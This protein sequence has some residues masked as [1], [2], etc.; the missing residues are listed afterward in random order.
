MNTTKRIPLKEFLTQPDNLAWV[1]QSMV[2]NAGLPIG[3]FCD[4]VCGHFDIRDTLGNLQSK[5]CYMALKAMDR[6]GKLSL[7][8]MLGYEPVRAGLPHRPRCLDVPPPQPVGLPEDAGQLMELKIVMARTLPQ[9]KTWNTILEEEHYIGASTPPGRLIKYM[10]YADGQLAAAGCFCA[11]KLSVWEREEWIG[12]PAELMKLRRDEV[13]IGMGRYVVREGAHACRNLASKVLGAMVGAVRIDW[14]EKYRVEP[15]LI[16]TYVDPSRFDGTCYKAANWIYV[17][18]TSGRGRDD[19][20]HAASAGIKMI[21][22]YP[23]VPDFRKRLGVLSPEER[24]RPAWAADKA[25]GPWEG[26]KGDA[27]AGHE[28]GGSDLG[29]KARNK[30]LAYSA[31]RLAKSPQT[32]ISEAFHLDIPGREGLYRLVNN[33]VVTP[34]RILEG[35]SLRTRQRAK[36]LK[37]AVFAQDGL[38]VT[39][40]G[41][42]KTRGLGPV[43]TSASGSSVDGLEEHGVVL[44]DPAARRMLGVF[45]TVFWVRI[46]GGKGKKRLPPDERESAVWRDA[47]REIDEAAALMPDTRCVTVCDRG[48]DAL[49]FICEYLERGQSELIVRAKSDRRLLN[50]SGH[51]FSAMAHTPPCGKMTVKLDRVTER[52][53]CAG[54]IVVK[55]HP[56]MTVEVDVIFRPVTFAPPPEKPDFGPVSVVC[57]TVVERGM[58]KDHE[59]LRWHLLTTGE[60]KNAG[61]AMEVVRHYECRWVI[62][63]W[64]GMLKKDCCNIEALSCRTAEAVENVIAIYMVVAW[65]LMLSLHLARTEPE[66]PPDT[67]LDPLEMEI[68]QRELKRAEKKRKRRIRTL[69]DYVCLV[70]MLGGYCGYGSEWCHP[71]GAPPG[72]ATFARGYAKLRLMCDAVMEERKE[73][74]KQERLKQAE[75]TARAAAPDAEAA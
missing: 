57:V 20:N 12:W 7:K 55:G 8:D 70:A 23:L 59:R 45:R 43:W 26:L 52:R 5:N 29:N 44:I 30:R 47:G 48:A 63:E 15:M 69:L 21:F 4:L 34:D 1:Q 67:V 2:A 62:E 16:E 64:H 11:A 17:G 66:L 25:L 10:A 35:H 24:E 39:L 68:L 9:K 14:P 73:R 75:A 28:F 56:A 31:V 36:G 61:Q 27:W 22:M 53:D 41:K 65:W 49:L 37:I 42:P 71:N 72:Y 33:E 18:E 46:R 58:P 13:L 50:E 38:T 32:S 74:L 54:N 6:Q 60:V 51:L 19:R 40:K 3:K